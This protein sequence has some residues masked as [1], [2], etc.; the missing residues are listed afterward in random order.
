MKIIHHDLGF[1][2]KGS[3][4]LITLSG[5][6]ANVRLLDQT[7]YEYY[8]KGKSNYYVGAL[9]ASSQVRLSIPYAGS[10]H[11]V[12]DLQGL[13]GTVTSSVKIL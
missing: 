12:V 7:N 9:A 2:N 8:L 10:W 3:V 13:S 6:P 5:D 1:Q 11:V 4:V